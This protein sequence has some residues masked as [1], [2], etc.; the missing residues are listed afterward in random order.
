MSH[1]VYQHSPAKGLGNRDPRRPYVT[2]GIGGGIPVFVGE[3]IPAR[4]Y[5]GDRSETGWDE[6]EKVVPFGPPWPVCENHHG[7]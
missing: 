7:T 5:E 2:G 3:A 1:F 6:R 4:T